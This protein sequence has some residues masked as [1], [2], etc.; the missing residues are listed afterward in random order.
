[1]YPDVKAITDNANLIESKDSDKK[2]NEESVAINELHNT[3]NESMKPEMNMQ[4]E[5]NMVLD[6]AKVQP[7]RTE[8]LTSLN[9]LKSDSAKP[10]LCKQATSGSIVRQTQDHSTPEPPTSP[11]ISATN[12]KSVSEESTVKT[13]DAALEGATAEEPSADDAPA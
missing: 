8:L 1:M 3:E 2:K 10:V 6:Q 5:D 11:Q 4:V 7:R 13:V 9:P 12:N